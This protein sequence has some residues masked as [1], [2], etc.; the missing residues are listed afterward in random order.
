MFRQVKVRCDDYDEFHN[1]E[2][3]V[4][5][6]H[7]IHWMILSVHLIESWLDHTQILYK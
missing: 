4:Y 5:I 6:K 1:K 7:S 3:Y 2:R